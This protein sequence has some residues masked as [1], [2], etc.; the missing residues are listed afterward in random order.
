MV[1]VA[2]EAEVRRVKKEVKKAKKQK[3]EEK[4]EREK[5]GVSGAWQ[6]AHAEIRLWVL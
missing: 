4:T 3:R 6:Q 2:A 5:V 1:D